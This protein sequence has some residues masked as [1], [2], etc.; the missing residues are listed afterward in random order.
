MDGPRFHYRLE[1]TYDF[2]NYF[3]MCTS[4]DCLYGTKCSIGL[5]HLLMLLLSFC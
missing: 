5:V 4:V 1:C 2:L 3:V